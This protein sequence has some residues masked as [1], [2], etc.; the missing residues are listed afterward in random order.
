MS[1]AMA[2]RAR[3]AYQTS[4]VQMQDPMGLVVQLYDGMLMFLRRGADL[5][6]TGQK[7][8]AAEP[9]R[10]AMDIIGEL[11]GVLNLK[12][13]GEVASNLD[14][15][16]SYCRRRVM[17]AHIKADPAGLEEIARLLTPMRDAWSEAR[18]KQMRL[19]A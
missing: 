9:I 13:G 6:A 11:Q 3:R 7:H 16:Y 19:G 14:R 10:R 17:E 1:Y 8:A 5:L 15:I 2:D 12:E 4:A 18:L